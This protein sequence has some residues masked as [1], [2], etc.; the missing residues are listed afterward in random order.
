MYV[1]KNGGGGRGGWT[2]WQRYWIRNLN[3]KTGIFI[4][5]NFT[6]HTSTVYIDGLNVFVIKML[7]WCTHFHFLKVTNNKQNS[8]W[9][10]IPKPPDP[11][12]R[13]TSVLKSSLVWR[14]QGWQSMCWVDRYESRTCWVWIFPSVEGS[15]LCWVFMFS[16][17]VSPRCSGFYPQLKDAR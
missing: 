5:N 8:L 11:Q 17:W 13:I 6:F 10:L 15:F 16:L 2:G 4:K 1:L 7:L 14:S 9:N 12:T 3:F